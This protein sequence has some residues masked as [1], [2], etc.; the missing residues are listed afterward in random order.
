[1]RLDE[2]PTAGGGGGGGQLTVREVD[3]SGGSDEGDI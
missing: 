3:K 2:T 1:M